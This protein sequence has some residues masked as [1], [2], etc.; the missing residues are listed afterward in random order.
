M[1]QAFLETS[2]PTISWKISEELT[3]ILKEDPAQVSLLR[4]TEVPPELFPS[5]SLD[6][7]QLAG[8]L[9]PPSVLFL[10]SLGTPF[11]GLGVQNLSELL[12]SQGVRDWGTTC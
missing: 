11:G 12:D 8:P 2:L 3:F 5:I 4:I 7:S 6:S 1:L 9:L 10:E